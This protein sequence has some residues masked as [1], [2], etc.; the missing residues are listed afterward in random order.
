MK[1][2]ILVTHQG[3]FL[4]SASPN[5]IALQDIPNDVISYAKGWSNMIVLTKANTLYIHLQNDNYIKPPNV[6]KNKDKLQKL[7]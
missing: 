5:A 7:P 6:I 4:R 3:N 2:S 1:D